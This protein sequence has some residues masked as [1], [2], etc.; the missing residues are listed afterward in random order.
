MREMTE[1]TALSKLAALCS[2]GEHCRQDIRQRLLRWGLDDEAQARIMQRLEEEHYVDD[3]RFCQAYV[4][5]KVSYDRWGRRKIELALRAKG[6]ADD[7]SRPVLDA[8]DDRVY[9]SALRPLLQSKLRTMKA[10]DDYDLACKLTRFAMQRGYTMDIIR[11][12]ID[13]AAA[14]D[15]E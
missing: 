12:C 1:Q 14:A 15:D 4:H 11:Q 8:V 3:R 6:I 5:D 7:I 13:I 10:R 2:T 9:V